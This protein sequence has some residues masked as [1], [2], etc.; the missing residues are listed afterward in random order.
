MSESG[1]Q[2]RSASIIIDKF[3]MLDQRRFFYTYKNMEGR[4]QQFAMTDLKSKSSPRQHK[5]QT[6]EN[7]YMA[8]RDRHRSMMH[9]IFSSKLL[10]EVA[11][12][13]VTGLEHLPTSFRGKSSPRSPRA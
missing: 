4:Q 12:R 13:Q 1:S 6:T 5:S 9:D 11:E 8:Q 2:R 7:S 3:Y 10:S